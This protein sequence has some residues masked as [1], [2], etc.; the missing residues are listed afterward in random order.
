MPEGGVARRHLKTQE[1]AATTDLEKLG[2]KKCNFFLFSLGFLY[3]YFRK[4]NEGEFSRKKNEGGDPEN[5][6]AKKKSNF[7]CLHGSRKTNRGAAVA[8]ATAAETQNAGRR[9]KKSKKNIYI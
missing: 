5:T 1:Q 2:R 3:G 7:F 4:S 8:T 9:K 6:G